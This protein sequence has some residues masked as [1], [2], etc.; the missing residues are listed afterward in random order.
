M[1]EPIQLALTMVGARA[2][3]LCHVTP[4]SN[5]LDIGASQALLSPALR[6]VAPTHGWGPNAVIA[7]R[8]VCLSWRPS[9]GLVRQRFPTVEKVI[10]EFDAIEIPNLPTAKFVPFNAAAG[11]AH[12][13]IAG[14]IEQLAALR[15]CVSRAEVLVK[16]EVLVSDEVP[17]SALRGVHFSDQQ[18]KE[19]WWPL[20]RSS[21]CSAGIPC[22]EAR[23]YAEGVFPFLPS[24][25]ITTERLRPVF[26]GVDRRVR[27]ISAAPALT[28]AEIDQVNAEDRGGHWMDDD[29]WDEPQEVDEP[30]LYDDYSEESSPDD[31][32]L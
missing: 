19:A 25:F 4:A 14:E 10:L 17:L 21:I 23:V 22:P 3:K 24:E 6:G 29:D 12:R 27:P 31:P 16:A 5:L 1:T 13:Y 30:P 18:A 28:P 11:E 2:R 8:T 26:E 7:S 9:W 32:E 15:E 20:F